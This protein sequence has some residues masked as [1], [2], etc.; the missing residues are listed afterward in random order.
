MNF[1][2]KIRHLMDQ[3]HQEVYEKTLIMLQSKLDIV[4]YILQ[5]ITSTEEP[6]VTK[7]VRYLRNKAAL[8]E[9]IQSLSVWQALTDQSWFL[10]MTLVNPGVEAALVAENHRT[11]RLIPS[12]SLI[13]SSLTL[14]SSG[15][16]V[17]SLILPHGEI[18]KMER[19]DIT[20][21]DAKIGKRVHRQGNS[22]SYV[23]NEISGLRSP[24]GSQFSRYDIARDD[25][26]R[27]ARRLQ[28]T[29]PATFGL[30]HCKG[31]TLS[32]TKGDPKITLLLN[33]PPDLAPNPRSLRDLLLNTGPPESLSQRF[34]VAQGLAKSI[35]YVHTFGFVHKNVRPESI[36]CFSGA[37]ETITATYLI[38]FELFRR[39]M[40][41]TQRLGDTS[42][43]KDLYRHISRQGIDPKWNY[44]MQ[45]DIYS[46]GV[47]LLEIGLWKSFIDYAIHGTSTTTTLQPADILDFPANL[48]ESQAA[49]HLAT[50]GAAKLVSLARNDLPRYMGTKYSE[51]VIT[52]LTCLHGSN[53]DFGDDLESEDAQGVP[54]G[55]RFVEKVVIS[56]AS[57]RR[58]LC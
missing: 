23:L 50:E 8:D 57:T 37:H 45:H 29:E 38:G 4:K 2:Q 49:H 48:N 41:W 27:L 15:T 3:G 53:D 35:S 1:S 28:H 47:C 12:A 10:F 44:I 19:S 46:L 58:H 16:S 30:L 31:F 55:V 21:S 34:Q 43:D 17:A 56:S 39:D 13:R 40:G 33:I 11:T 18:E 36:L 52:C 42:L 32:G 5:G 14:D 51:I 24:P 26:G 54:V 20:L 22:V 7:R 9:A 25:T 6:N